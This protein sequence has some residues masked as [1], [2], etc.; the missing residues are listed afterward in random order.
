MPWPI[1]GAMVWAV[2]PGSPLQPNE[3]RRQRSVQRWRRSS[4]RFRHWSVHHRW[5]FAPVFTM[6][7][8]RHCGFLKPPLLKIR[9]PVKRRA[10][11]MSPLIT[12]TSSQLTSQAMVPAAGNPLKVHLRMYVVL[13]DT[14]DV[15]R[16]VVPWV[17]GA[18]ARVAAWLLLAL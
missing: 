16:R 18:G 11:S 9:L 2:V 1:C 10:R 4:P 13:S 5:P 15:C 7:D 6:L 12:G 3:C 8:Q 17:L 14:A